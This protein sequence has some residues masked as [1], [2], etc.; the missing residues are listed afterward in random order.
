MITQERLKEL[1]HYDPD[2]GVFTWRVR[3][4]STSAGTFAGAKAKYL[5]IGIDGITYT[6]HRLAFLYMM[7]YMPEVVDHRDLDKHNNAWLNLREGTNSKNQANRNVSV[8]NRLGVK[9]VSRNGRGYYAQL[10]KDGKKYYSKT[11]HTLELAAQA[12]AELARKHHGEFA[13]H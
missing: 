1:L 13:R 2:T 11:Y 3:R 12:Y 8:R 4:G 9:G 5:N 6:G 10:S 7:G